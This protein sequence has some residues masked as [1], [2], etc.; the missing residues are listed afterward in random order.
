MFSWT[1]NSCSISGTSYSISVLNLHTVRETRLHST[2]ASAKPRHRHVLLKPITSSHNLD[3]LII[4]PWWDYRGTNLTRKCKGILPFPT[5]TL[6]YPSLR[7]LSLGSRGLHSLLPRSS[8]SLKQDLDCLKGDICVAFP[9][10]PFHHCILPLIV[11]LFVTNSFRTS[12]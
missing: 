7:P 1:A 2:S 5:P 4:N 11:S 10:L 8:Y 3:Q 6:L 9:A 12:L